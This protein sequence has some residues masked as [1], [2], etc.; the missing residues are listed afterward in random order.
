[1][2]DE[3][4]RYKLELLPER[5]LNEILEVK[6]KTNRWNLIF[7]RKYNNESNS[8]ENDFSK[9]D[10][11]SD[12]NKLVRVNSSVLSAAKQIN[13]PDAVKIT[14][15]FSKIQTSFDNIDAS[16]GNCFR[17]L[18][19][20]SKFYYENP[21]ILKKVEKMLCRFDLGISKL[22]IEEYEPTDSKKIYV[23]NAY[24]KVANSDIEKPL[25]M[26]NESG[27]TRNLFILLKD[28]FTALETGN[29]VI[30]DELDN[31]LH[32]LMVPEIVSLFNSKKHNPN[33]AQLFFSTHNVQILSELDKQQIIITEK[34]GN[35][36]QAWRLDDIEGVRVDENYYAKY[37]AG[38]YGG[39]P[40]F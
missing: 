5:V 31:N 8:Y 17:A 36:S 3:V 2:S 16:N 15:Y 32:P 19:D 34:E 1:M 40:R 27:G 23:P 28:I 14:E 26:H 9:L 38:A 22:S 35:T 39:I 25:I 7:S 37:L 21:V 13:N 11:P 24:H 30:F 6:G 10:L 29:T 12:F 4:Y 33:N 18:F 20:V